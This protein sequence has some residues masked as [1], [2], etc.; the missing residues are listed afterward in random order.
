MFDLENSGADQ[1]SSILN[2]PGL[3]RSVWLVIIDKY[4]DVKC[5]PIKSGS[6]RAG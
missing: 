1:C 4:G 2:L 6:N 5:G 3:R